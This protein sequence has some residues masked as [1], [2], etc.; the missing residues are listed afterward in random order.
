[1]RGV[2]A[3]SIVV[4]GMVV[5]SACGGEDGPALFV[6]LRTDYRSGSEIDAVRTEIISADGPG[7]GRFVETP[8]SAS[9]DY[10]SG[11]RVAELYDLADGELEIDVSLL[12]SGS[13]VAERPLS[14]T[15][16][17]PTA[18]TILIQRACR[19]VS[20]S[21]GTACFAGRCVDARCSQGDSERCGSA[22]CSSAA[23]CPNGDACFEAV[24]AGNGCLYPATGGACDFDGGVGDAGALDGSVP[25]GASV[26][27]G[28]LDT[29]VVRDGSVYCCGGNSGGQLGM[30]TAG[31]AVAT[32]TVVP[33]IADAVQASVSS[34]HACAVH[35][36]GAVSC[37]GTNTDGR[38]GNGTTTSS[39]GPVDVV[40]LV[41]AVEVA[42][43]SVFTCARTRSGHVMCW[44]HNGRG[45]LGIGSISIDHRETPV[46]ALNLEDAVQL[47]AGGLHLCARRAS[48]S[49][50]CWGRNDERQTGIDEDAVYQPTDVPGI[51]GVT[52]VAAGYA[53]TCVVVTDGTVRCWGANTTAQ[54][55]AD[56]SPMSV[57]PVTVTLARAVTRVAAGGGHSC[58]LERAGGV[59]CW[60]SNNN[61]QLVMS[62]PNTPTP[63]PITG[64]PALRTIVG[65]MHHTCGASY[66]DEILCWGGNNS[67]QLG[68]ES[69]GVPGPPTVI[70]VP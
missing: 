3:I 8:A 11:A 56:A 14:V 57:A 70:S 26:A 13:I 2:V 58:A 4:L 40:D 6:D 12:L 66:D 61:L 41:D 60:G 69:G 46:E 47:V 31:V 16:H 21:T 48:G 9:E 28:N 7:A 49:V 63:V 1:M 5:V 68:Y 53:H 19:S 39:F 59:E 35:A 65:G 37:W 33:G 45:W 54:L 30:D 50:A 43:G 15:V 38:L 25:L 29:C 18:V 51:E 17:G 67:G 34:G 44:G 62:G 23:D 10:V 27:A 32:P 55:G 42:A 36:S 22:E 64:A 24:C 20:C 52:D